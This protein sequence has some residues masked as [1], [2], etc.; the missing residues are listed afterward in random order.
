[1]VCRSAQIHS[2]GTIA[3]AIGVVLEVLHAKYVCWKYCMQ[4]MLLVFMRLVSFQMYGRSCTAAY[5][6]HASF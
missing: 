3:P 1:M 2:S 4:N 5:I 6:R